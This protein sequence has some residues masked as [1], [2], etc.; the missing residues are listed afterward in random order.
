M[1][2]EHEAVDAIL[3]W[4]AANRRD[5]PWRRTRDPYAIWISE[6]MLQ[7]TQAAAV[8]PYFERWMAL[9][10]TL[11]SLAAADEQDVLGVWQGLGYYRRCR[12]L[13][14]GA[15]WLVE[16]GVPRTA[17]GWRI[18]PGV[19]PYTASAIASIAFG[20]AASVVDGNVERVFARFTGCRESGTSL[21]RSARGWAAE[22]VRAAEPG[23][24]NQALMELG[25]IVCTSR[26]PKCDRCPIER[27]CVAR[28]S[29]TVEELPVHRV[30]PRVVRYSQ[31]VWVPYTEGEFGI[32]RVPQGGWWEGMWTFPEA[33][34]PT[35]E[36]PE[37]QAAK[38]RALCGEGWLEDLGRFRYSVT[39]HSI[40]ADVWLLRS[41]ERGDRLRW[42][43][44]EE[45]P[46]LPMPSP[47]R[48]ALALAIG[49]LGLPAP[50]ALTRFQAI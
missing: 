40:E 7:Q 41:E 19:G 33:G 24:W 4:Y 6:V 48:R 36:E 12:R 3:K 25:A 11:G 16:H 2:L 10:P 43:R 31:L 20:E 47:Q 27:R 42:V 5:L 46:S 8:A 29:W 35:P 15:K 18:V 50:P 17:E 49:R 39:Q 14:A 32:V 37:E 30:R 1:L 28:N 23:S 34:L 26:N 22:N 44:L 13:L 45:L 38:L 9:F 21:L